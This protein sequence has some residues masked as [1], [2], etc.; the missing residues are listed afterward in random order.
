VKPA[1][2]L[3]LIGLLVTSCHRR[4]AKLGQQIVGSWKREGEGG[5]TMTI[6]PEGGFSSGSSS[7]A[8]QGT[9]RVK[10]TEL[11]ITLT[12]ATG[13]KQRESVGIV[14][15]MKIVQA[16]DNSLMLEQNGQTIHYERR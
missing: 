2:I 7:V 14:D 16:D 11:V 6:R 10:N 8:Y 4:D 15:R 5:F 9:W 13:F 12:N 3:L 1:L